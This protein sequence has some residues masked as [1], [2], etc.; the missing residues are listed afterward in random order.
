M[1]TF[2]CICVPSERIDLANLESMQIQDI[3]I[4]RGERLI[5]DLHLSKD[6]FIP[7]QINA[8]HHIKNTLY[9]ASKGYRQ[10]RFLI[11]AQFQSHVLGFINSL[12]NQN[13]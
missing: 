3:L 2:K 7:K 9:A 12:D 13:P 6:R 11:A 10:D 1:E 5:F 4:K 8:I